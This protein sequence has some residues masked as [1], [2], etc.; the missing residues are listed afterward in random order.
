MRTLFVMSTLVTIGFALTGCQETYQ[1]NG[2]E[3]VD[4]TYVHKYGVEV[5]SYDWSA[6]GQDGQVVSTLMNGVVVSKS[7]SGGI[8]NGDTSY[9]FPHSQSIEK[10]ETYSQGNLTKELINSLSGAPLQDTRIQP[11][12]A[13]SITIWYENGSPKSIESYNPTGLLVHGEYY[14]LRHQM[15]ASIDNQEGIR[16]IRDGYGQLLSK[17]TVQAGKMTSRTTFYPNGAPQDITP[18]SNGIVEGQR[19][20]FLPAGEP[21]SV[22]AWSG[23]KQ[24]GITVLYQNGEKNA[25]ISY[26]G[27]MKNGVERHYR[28]GST[29]VEE[30]SWRD[31]LRHGPS[32]TYVGSTVKTNWFSEGQ[33]VSENNFELLNGP[34]VE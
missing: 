6:R 18:F 20:C 7:Y 21:K 24:S 19:K 12:G 4:T 28:D 27:G 30:I 8:L 17:D 9:T 33:P 10:V 26:A 1:G 34:W 31:N 32:R 5:P 3:V 22:E 25:E 29:V 2:A 14:D 16:I 13:K 15:E 11:D 23:G